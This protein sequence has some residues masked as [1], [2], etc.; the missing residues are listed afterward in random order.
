MFKLWETDTFFETAQN[1]EYHEDCRRSQQDGPPG[2][3]DS[4]DLSCQAQDAITMNQNATTYEALYGGSMEQQKEDG[5]VAETEEMSDTEEEDESDDRANAVNF[6]A[7]PPQD[8]FFPEA[9]ES[10]RTT[11]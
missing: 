8:F 9:K 7:L 11:G 4:V 5:P 1:E 10:T 3:D 2:E 6:D